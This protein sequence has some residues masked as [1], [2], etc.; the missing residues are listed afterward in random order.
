MVFIFPDFPSVFVW[1]YRHDGKNMKPDL[2]FHG[3][4]C[5][6]PEKAELVAQQLQEK[7][8]QALSEFKREKISKQRSR[9][10]HENFMQKFGELA[11]MFVHDGTYL[12]ITCDKSD[13]ACEDADYDKPKPKE[14]ASEVTS[15]PMA[16]KSSN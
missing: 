13:F 1:I 10:R 4:L 6:K 9:M 15:K 7:I 2:R 14:F 8:R 5:T 16:I 11:E 12:P 3:A